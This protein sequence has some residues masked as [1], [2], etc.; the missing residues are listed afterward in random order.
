MQACMELSASDEP[1]TGM[2]S[3]TVCDD[4]AGLDFDAL[5]AAATRRGL[6]SETQD[7]L[8]EAMFQ[9]GISTRSEVTEISGRG[10]GMSALRAVC[11]DMGGSVEVTTGSNQG[12]TIRVRVRRGEVPVVDDTLSFRRPRTSAGT[13]AIT[14][15]AIDDYLTEQAPAP[16]YIP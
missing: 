10:V 13:G 1:Q 5:R 14:V 12:T 8:I 2:V 6:R 16:F 15:L 7:D 3:I 9:D 11:Q 4:G